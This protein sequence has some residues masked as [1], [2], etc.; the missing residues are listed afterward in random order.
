MRA[1]LDAFATV[2]AIAAATLMPPLLVAA[3]GVVAAPVP[4]P[5]SAF[6]RVSA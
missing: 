2:T 4:A 6:P 1:V 3:L 5:V